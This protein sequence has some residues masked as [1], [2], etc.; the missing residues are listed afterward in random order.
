MR[1]HKQIVAA[2]CESRR[3]VNRDYLVIGNCPDG[4]LV[5]LDNRHKIPS[6]GYVSIEEAGDEEVWDEY[7]AC[8]SPSLGS[9]VRT[10]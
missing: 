8:I 9:S 3:R 7:C 5:V 6:V 4:N 1:Q 10:V 2:N